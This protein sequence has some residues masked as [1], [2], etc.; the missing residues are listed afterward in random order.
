[1]R[2]RS[3]TDF[4]SE[5]DAVLPFPDDRRAEIVEEIASHLDDAVAD[6]LAESSAQRRLGEPADLAR[7]LARPE[8]SV[9]RVVAGVGAALRSGIGHWL[10]GYLLGS[11]LLLLGAL[12]SAGLVQLMGALFGTG[13]SLLTADQGWNTMLV[14]LA[15]A[16]G[17]YYAGRVIPNRVARTTRHLERDVRPWTVGATTML[18][19]AIALFVVDAPQ[20]WASVIALAMAP[21]AIAL[22]AYRPHLVP[23]GLRAYAAILVLALTL[24]VMILLMTGSGTSTNVNVADGP[25]DRNL[26]QV[27][28]WWPPSAGGD[29]LPLVESGGWSQM[30]NGHLLWHATFEPGV[31]AELH[32]L[33]LEAWHSDPATFSIND[34]FTEPFAV[35]TPSRSDGTLTATLNTASEPGVGAWQL[36]LTGVGPDGVRYIL[37]AGSGGN[38]TFT[39]SVWDWVTAVIGD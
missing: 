24:P 7:D 1:V 2:E 9:W 31:L 38:S 5:L 6:G 18:A 26:G 34:R 27:G 30:G 25:L 21:G 32:G 13:W 8:Q 3:R 28:P 20:N 36:V 39:G 35:A 15:G 22:G 14:A 17:L 33:R 11:L 4:L 16:F 37:D 23:P 10:Y 29:G 12:G 19:L